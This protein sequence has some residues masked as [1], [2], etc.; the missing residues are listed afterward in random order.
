[1]AGLWVVVLCAIAMPA[2]LIASPASCDMWPE[3]A[4]RFIQDDGRV[5]EYSQHSRTTS[6]GQAYA[7]FFALVYNDQARFHAIVSWVN[8]NMAGGHLGKRLPAWL[9]G[10]NDKHQWGVL[11]KHAASDADV[12]MAYTLI[13]AAR[14]W[15]DQAYLNMGKAM[16][17]RIEQ[18]EVTYLE[19]IGMVLLP[20]P[21]Q[22]IQADDHW[23]IN[24]SYFAFPLLRFFAIY[25]ESY[26][27]SGVLHSSQQILLQY[28]QHGLVPDWL[29]YDRVEKQLY[30]SD[31]AV[32]S[33]DAIRSYMWVAML[34]A[35]DGMRRS[36]L[37]SLDGIETFM[38]RNEHLPS[39]ISLSSAETS[40]QSETGFAAAL[41]PY[42]K[43]RSMHDVYAR[44]KVWVL[45]QRK[46]CLLGAPAKYYEN[47]LA[48]FSQGWDNQAFSFGLG[49]ELN[50]LWH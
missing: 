33:Y 17:Q 42:L 50:V 6:E 11:D 1:M 5:V 21:I 32:M 44:Q 24:P 41:L 18:D 31:D 16:L 15:H 7:M 34:H 28:N 4:K 10:E 37:E 27:W 45:S 19:H 22:V 20:T 26:V 35:D 40:E 2:K 23:R 30:A 38:H 49:G 43:V 8:N 13:Q 14:L 25:S 36:L 12:W 29:H 3:Y 48:L 46:D 47:N 39:S 9:W